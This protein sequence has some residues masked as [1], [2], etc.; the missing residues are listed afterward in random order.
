VVAGGSGGAAAG[1]T[2]AKKRPPQVVKRQL[3]EHV[4]TRWYRPPE[5]ILTQVMPISVTHHAAASFPAEH[6][7]QSFSSSSTRH[8]LV[9]LF[10]PFPSGT[11][12]RWTFGLS[13]AYSRSFYQRCGPPKLGVRHWY[14]GYAT[15]LHAQC[16]RCSKPGALDFFVE[17]RTPPPSHT[18]R[19][20]S[21]CFRARPASPSVPTPFKLTSP[22]ATSS[23]SSLMSLAHPMWQGWRVGVPAVPLW[24]A[25]VRIA[26]AVLVVLCVAVGL[27]AGMDDIA[28]KYLSS[29]KPTPKRLVAHSVVCRVL[30][31]EGCCRTLL[32]SVAYH[33]FPP[34][35][36]PPCVC[37]CV[38]V[39]VCMCV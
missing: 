12:W 17:D 31:L 22:S 26:L 27:L 11:R 14:G 29:L 7:A 2:R 20:A 28:K 8:G 1:G 33:H 21:P 6:T 13:A 3:T 35:L 9:S 34:T 18:H 19:P 4:V 37:M 38:C 30:P 16:S 15:T 36:T 23:T 10:V 5:V 25:V 39:C 24:C 32:K